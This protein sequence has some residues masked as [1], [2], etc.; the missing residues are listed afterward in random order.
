MASYG[1]LHNSDLDEMDRI[2]D[3][4]AYRRV[5][6]IVVNENGETVQCNVYVAFPRGDI[7]ADQPY[8][9]LIIAAAK[10]AGLPQHWI[11]RIEW[12]RS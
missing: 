6:K 1:A 9:E 7:A 2:E 10:S 5:K 4:K 12:F 11:Q 8:L 3:P